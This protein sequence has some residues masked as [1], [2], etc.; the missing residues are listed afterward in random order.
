MPSH[1]PFSSYNSSCDRSTKLGP[2]GSVL[3]HNS[4]D[5]M[6][7]AVVVD[8]DVVVVVAATVFDDVVV[9]VVGC[10]TS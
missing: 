4:L 6:F 1:Q 7:D 5:R 3:R 10:T 9:V 8:D 2:L